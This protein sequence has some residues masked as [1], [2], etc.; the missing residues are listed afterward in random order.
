[1]QS[2]TVDQTM[3]RDRSLQPSSDMERHCQAI[4]YQERTVPH[5]NHPQPRI[6]KGRGYDDISESQLLEF[7][8]GILPD[9][10]TQFSMVLADDATRLRFQKRAAEAFCIVDHEK[11]VNR[12]PFYPFSHADQILKGQFYCLVKGH[13]PF[14]F[15]D[16]ADIAEQVLEEIGTK[17][18][19]N[20]GK[21][22]QP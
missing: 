13:L 5:G 2:Q 6:Y 16:L 7:L 15:E 10:H 8:A 21:E 17:N 12:Q 11:Y 14:S 3:K 18:V 22:C 1:M 9:R 19:T 20:Q 4:V